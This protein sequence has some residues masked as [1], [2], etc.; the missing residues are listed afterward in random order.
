MHIRRTFSLATGF[1]AALMLTA[2][3]AMPVPAHAVIPVKDPINLIPNT[4]SAVAEGKQ[5]LIDEILDGLAWTAAKMTVQSIT[6]STVNWINS[7]FQGSPAFVTDL[8]ANFA[9]LGDAI[10]DDFFMHLDQEVQMAT[11]FNLTT[12][13]QDQIN[14][15]LRQEYY[16][17][18]ASWGLDYTLN[19]FSEDPRAFIDQGRFNQGGFNAFFA[20]SQNPANNP[21]GAYTRA[22]NELWRRIGDARQRRM[23]ELGFG[24]GFLPWRG[25]C[26]TA[27]AAGGAQ[28]LSRA[29]GCPFNSVRTPGSVIEDQ[30]AHTLGSGVR[31]LELADSINEIVGAL[32]GQLV[33]QVL[34]AGG[35][36]GTSMPG[37]GGGA[38]FLDRLASPAQF[39]GVTGSLADGMLQNMAADRRRV[40]T[41]IDQWTRVRAAAAAAAS[42]CGASTLTSDTLVRADTAITKG[43]TAL[44]ELDAID[45]RIRAAQASNGSN[46]SALISDAVSSYQSYL[47]SPSVPTPEELAT[48]AIE[49]SDEGTETLQG[50]RNQTQQSGTPSLLTQLN[51]QAAS[52][53]LR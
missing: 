45:Q 24:R 41:Y 31:Q 26:R 48:A 39:D 50:S 34:G 23:A 10:A 1:L 16:R 21:F 18:T 32:M 49:S 30:L 27:A 22:S 43:R 28:N 19:Q 7:G 9:Y 12:P 6:R 4:A 47:R 8:Q 51:R 46:R 53:A 52:C 35:L 3:I 37:P 44:S 5:T 25:P 36:I 15:Q 38:T 40:T 11:G 17:T 29:E 2:G 13:F 33:N 14:W 42:R 20:A